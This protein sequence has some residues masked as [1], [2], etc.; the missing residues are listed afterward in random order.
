MSFTYQP[1]KKKRASAHGFLVR[2]RT[3]NGS[4]VLARRRQ[5]GRARLSV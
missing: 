2:S 3:K 4:R 1:K 5:K